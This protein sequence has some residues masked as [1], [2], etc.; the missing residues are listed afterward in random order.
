MKKLLSVAAVFLS[1]STIS[2]SAKSEIIES[3]E[4]TTASASE[5]AAVLIDPLKPDAPNKPIEVRSFIEVDAGIV[6]LNTKLANQ[7]GHLNKGKSVS[8]SVGIILGRVRAGVG[9]LGVL[10]NDQSANNLVD[11]DGVEVENADIAFTGFS[12]FGGGRYLYLDKYEFNLDVGITTMG[13]FQISDEVDALQASLNTEGG[14]F[15]RPSFNYYITSFLGV[16]A[17]Y[18][19]MLGSDTTVKSMLS[20]GAVFKL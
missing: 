8:A 16:R 20:L 14:L 19:H 18:F 12:A 1:V 4:S 10:P 2:Y 17:S 13:H 15:I 11:V 6:A 9:A 7:Q 3:T 5:P